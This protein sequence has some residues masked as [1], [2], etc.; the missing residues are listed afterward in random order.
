VSDLDKPEIIS[1]TEIYRSRWVNL[2][3]DW[4]RFPNGR[5]IE[6]HHL[7]DFDHAAVM[8]VPQGLDGRYLMVK[9]CR[10][11]TGRTDWEFPA[12][13]IEQDEAI[14]TAAQREVLEET[15]Y[16]AFDSQVIYTYNPL[17]G[18]ANQ[19]FYVVRCRVRG[20]VGV[21]DADEITSVQ[22][23]NEDEIWQMIRSGEMKDGYSLTAFLLNKH[24]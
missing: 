11:P 1:R 20:P 4:V 9:V 8:A 23:F 3:V 14:I 15:G 7:L 18:I 24:L 2:Y 10:H 5:I 16:T 17:N 13:S 22:W 6:Q 19:V 12:G 21:Y